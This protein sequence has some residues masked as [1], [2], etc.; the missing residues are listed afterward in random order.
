MYVT[1]FID[2]F[3]G[4]GP[5]S[6]GS[7]TGFLNG[8]YAPFKVGD[9]NAPANFSTCAAASPVNVSDGY[10]NVANPTLATPVYFVR[11]ANEADAVV[12]LP[13]RSMWMLGTA[14]MNCPNVTRGFFIQMA[15]AT[16]N[17][18]SP[19]FYYSG[20]FPG[21]AYGPATYAT[22]FGVPSGSTYGAGPQVLL[23]CNGT[24]PAYS[25]LNF[26][27]F[28]SQYSNGNWPQNVYNWNTPASCSS[29]PSYINSNLAQGFSLA[30]GSGY[31]G[32]KCVPAQRL[33]PAG[34]RSCADLL[35]LLAR[36]ASIIR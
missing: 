18:P 22:P 34:L 3:H 15:A 12:G 5:Y 36:A 13:R 26:S 1:G 28:M 10:Y 14:N 27:F 32:Y 17:T 21:S 8:I 31:A 25:S 11:S 23:A 29:L 30:T 9:G 33:C 35:V 2:G 4:T 6:G 7:A 20:D 19:S 16:G 24:V